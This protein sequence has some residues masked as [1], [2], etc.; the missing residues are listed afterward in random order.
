MKKA[1]GSGAACWA[2]PHSPAQRRWKP[3]ACA[4]IAKACAWTRRC[5]RCG[6]EMDE[7]PEAT[8]EQK[9]AGA[10]IELHIEQG[11]VLEKLELPLGVVLG[12][13]GVERHAIT[14]HGQEAHS[15][16]TPMNAR[17]DALA[18]CAK[19]A[20]E[21]RRHCDETRGCGLHHGQRE[22]ISGNRDGGG[23]ALRSD[24]RSARSGRASA[25]D[26]VSRGARSERTVCERGALH[27]GMVAHLADR[28]DRVSSEDGGIV[29]RS[30]SRDGGEVASHAVRAAARCGGSF[31]RGNS[32]GDDVRAVG[33][34]ISHNKIEDTKEEHLELAVRA[35]DRLASKAME[36]V[37]KG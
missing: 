19:L 11:P 5:E 17:H 27:G 7:F 2:L 37:A 26:D 22:N 21:I 3:I 33:G 34:G 29:R 28:A 4:P 32:D 15:G 35:F 31:A 30:D 18:A 23:G 16:S 9:N 10:Y 25:G 20:L 14:F 36:F 24:T 1:R 6:V 13:K 12:T 8:Q